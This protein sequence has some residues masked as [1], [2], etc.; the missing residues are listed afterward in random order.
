MTSTESGTEGEKIL[1]SS[2]LN[3]SNGQ[4]PLT[5]IINQL[6]LLQYA[7]RNRID[8]L[9]HHRSRLIYVRYG[10][11]DCRVWILHGMYWIWMGLLNERKSRGIS[12]IPNDRCWRIGFQLFWM[13]MRK[14]IVVQVVV[15]KRNQ[16]RGI[17]AERM[18]MHET[19][20]TQMAN[21]AFRDVENGGGNKNTMVINVGPIADVRLIPQ[22][23]QWT[24]HCT[25]LESDS[26]FNQI[27]W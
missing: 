9:H 12:C 7:K 17:F 26:T 14:G 22:W 6:P 10:V 27:P 1:A 19:I 3:N 13:R 23:T 2:L 8:W 5:T 16:R 4:I 18:S 24:Q 21:Y 20:A 11:R 25:N 15:V